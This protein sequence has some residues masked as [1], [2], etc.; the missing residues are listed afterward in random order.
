MLRSIHCSSRASLR[1]KERSRT[2][3]KL[4]CQNTNPFREGKTTAE[5][6]LFFPVFFFYFSSIKLPLSLFEANQLMILPVFP[7]NNYLKQ[8][9][10]SQ[11]WCPSAEL[12]SMPQI[13]AFMLRQWPHTKE[14]HGQ[15]VQHLIL[16]DSETG[17][18]RTVLPQQVLLLLNWLQLEISSLEYNSNR[19]ILLLFIAYVITYI[20]TTIKKKQVA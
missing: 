4:W 19:I 15:Q 12:I 13:S 2:P 18:S 16:C 1:S 14:K 11:H 6:N 5:V 3:D 9:A 17:V 7:V 20:L 8:L 10:E